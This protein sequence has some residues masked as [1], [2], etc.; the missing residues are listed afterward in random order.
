MLPLSMTRFFY[1]KYL[2]KNKKQPGGC[3]IWSGLV[4]RTGAK[5]SP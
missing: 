2:L 1:E 3:G 5:R 4:Q